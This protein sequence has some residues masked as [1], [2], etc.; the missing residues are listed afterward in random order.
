MQKFIN[1]SVKT[2]LDNV[3]QLPNLIFGVSNKKPNKVNS[4]D[5]SYGGFTREDW[6]KVGNDMKW[7][8][9]NFGKSR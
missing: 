8:L 2:V 9:I 7:G 4:S 6:K 1:L 3:A 5:N